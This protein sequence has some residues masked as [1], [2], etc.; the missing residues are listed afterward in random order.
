MIRAILD[1]LAFWDADSYNRMVR[2]ELEK[3]NKRKEKKDD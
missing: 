2:R 1:F 3:L